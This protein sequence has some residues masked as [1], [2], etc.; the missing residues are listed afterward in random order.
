VARLSICLLGSFWVTL[1]GD[2]VTNFESDK[3]RALLAYLGVEA[4]TPQRREKLAGMLWPE[5]PESVARANLRHALANLRLV[6]GDRQATSPFLLTTWQTIQFNNASDVWVDVAAF[7]DLAQTSHSPTPGTIERLETALELYRGSFLE[8]FSIPDSPAFEEWALLEGERLHRLAK[9]NL[10]SLSGWYE[11]CGEFELALNHA[12]RNVALDPCQEN[13]QQQLLRLLAYSGQREAALVQY[14]TYRRRL[15]E[16][17]G[18]EPSTQTEA[19][20]DRILDGSD[21]L[22]PQNKKRAT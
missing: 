15:A 16:E 17:L 12:W 1:D 21:L 3:V 20:Y 5:R 9:E 22:S 2:P 10:R 11:R 6:I 19:L 14:Q 4:E 7:T 13:A 18:V 8:G